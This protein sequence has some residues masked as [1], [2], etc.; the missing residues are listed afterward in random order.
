MFNSLLWSTTAS[1]GMFAAA[2]PAMAQDQP[3]PLNPGA[4]A[5]QPQPAGAKCRR[6]AEP[7]RGYRHRRHA[8]V[9]T[10]LRRSLQSARNIKRNSDQVVD[11]IVAEDIGKLPDITVSDTAARI[12]GIQVER[13]GGEASRVLLRGLDNTYYTTTYN[14]REI[15]TAETRSVALQDFPAGGIA[16]DRSVQDVDRE[17]GRA[18][19]RRPRQRPFAPS[20]RF[21]GPR[22][23]RFGLGA[24]TRTS[25]A[26]STP[27]GNFLLSDRWRRRRRRIRRADQLLLHALALSGFDP[28][29]RLLHRRSRRRR[30]RPTGRKSITTRATA[31]GPSV[32][33]A[34][35]W[36]RRQT[37]NFTPKAC[38]RAIART[39]SRQY[40]GAAAV[41][42]RRATTPTSCRDGTN[43]IVSGTVNEPGRLLRSATDAWGF[44]GAT[45]RETNTYQFAV[46]GSYDAGPL[47]HHRRP[48]AHQ[49]PLQAAHRERRLQINTHNYSVDWYTGLPGGSRPDLPGRRARSEPTRPIYHYR[50]F[51]EDYQT[52]RATI[53]RAGSTSNMTRSLDFI[54]EDPVGRSLRRPQRFR[55]GG[56]R[57]WNAARPAISIPISAVPLDYRAVPTRHSVATTTS[58]SRLTWL[59]PTFNSVWDNLTELR[60]FN[61]DLHRAYGSVNGPPINPA[62]TF[63]IN[64]KSLR[65]LRAAELQV[66]CRATRSVDGIVGIRVVRTKDNID[67]HVSVQTGGVATAVDVTER[68]YRLAAQREHQ[69]ALRAGMAASSGGDE[70]AH[71]ADVPATQP[72]AEPRS[73]DHRT[74]TRRDAAASAR[75][76]AAIR[77]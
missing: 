30:G 39:V 64:E 70:D 60:Q 36:R 12:P 58:P 19:H 10:G 18:G 31:G 61:I 63:N 67:G 51:F 24:F 23:R 13:D 37:S 59:A 20:V 7:R 3:A 65:R 68:L 72:G 34:L 29:P 48:R 25:R 57:Y 21:Q 44:Q 1:D 74:A 53:G 69:R 52:A 46:G 35:Q 14:G 26:T 41:G 62:R 2:S 9:V 32:N 8:I 16:R 42:R 77:S 17:P 47:T 6:A 22:D 45:K 75:A 40:V 15:F 27:N 54:P 55:H 71:P 73:A 5:Q 49:Q 33:G 28:P 43:E 38:G 4:T 76:A 50:G 11:A 56:D 66:R